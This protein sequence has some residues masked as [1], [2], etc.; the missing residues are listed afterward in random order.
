MM[1]GLIATS[2]AMAQRSDQVYPML[3]SV[4]SC[5]ITEIA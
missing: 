5:V 1:V 2:T 4:I 3:C